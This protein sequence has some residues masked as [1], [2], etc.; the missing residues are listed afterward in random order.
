MEDTKKT[1]DIILS[2][3]GTAS[4]YLK[5]EGDTSDATY[6][7]TF[8][9]KCFLTPLDLLACGKLYRE[10]L[11]PNSGEAS[12]QDKFIAVSLSQLSKR[13]T[14][15]PPFWNTDSIL[16]GNIPDL[17]ILS[18]VLDKALSAELLYKEQL[19]NKKEA[20]LKKSDESL[21]KLQEEMNPKVEEK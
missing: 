17:N 9:F 7:G 11:G 2:P 12:E 14:K 1:N 20:A 10:L 3:E 21:K 13:I 4:W 8:I 18:L 6:T 16:S 5:E 19:K 15:A